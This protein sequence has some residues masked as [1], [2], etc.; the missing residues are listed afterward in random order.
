MQGVAHARGAQRWPSASE[1]QACLRRPSAAAWEAGL[2]QSN[3]EDALVQQVLGGV[4][5]TTTQ[6]GEQAMNSRWPQSGLVPSAAPQHSLKRSAAAALQGLPFK[7]QRTTSGAD[8]ACAASASSSPEVGSQSQRKASALP[9]VPAASALSRSSWARATSG[10]AAD[11][12]RWGPRSAAWLPLCQLISMPTA[13]PR[14]VGWPGRL[15]WTE[16]AAPGHSS[17]QDRCFLGEG[18]PERHAGRAGPCDPEAL[19]VPGQP[20]LTEHGRNSGALPLQE[21]LWDPSNSGA[22]CRWTPPRRTGAGAHT[23]TG[24]CCPC[25]ISR[26]RQQAAVA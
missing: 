4:A 26:P 19:R 2:L 7:I 15:P 25:Q 18:D 24:P 14:G 20:G 23:G 3:R 9:P 16:P 13:Q 5:H 22:R 11:G 10:V 6:C 17:T 21:G 1:G 12:P 8:S